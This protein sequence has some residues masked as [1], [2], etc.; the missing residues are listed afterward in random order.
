MHESALS[1]TPPL[2]TPPNSTPRM[3]AVAA[4]AAGALSRLLLD[5]RYQRPLAIIKG[6][7][8]G[9]VYVSID[10]YSICSAILSMT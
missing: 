5:P 9:F 4:G 2:T 1:L 3:S 6:F 8:N 10:N 7:R